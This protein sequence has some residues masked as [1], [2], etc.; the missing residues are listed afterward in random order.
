MNPKT[1][2]QMASRGTASSAAYKFLKNIEKFGTGEIPQSENT[3]KYVVTNWKMNP[4]FGINEKVSM[5]HFHS[6]ENAYKY[7][8]RPRIEGMSTT[9]NFK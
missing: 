5:K 9:K 3:G 2:S 7:A 6:R 4:Q 1:A 8:N